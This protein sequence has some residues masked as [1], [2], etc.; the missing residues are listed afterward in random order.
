MRTAGAR[1]PSIRNGALRMQPDAQHRLELAHLGVESRG[2]LTAPFREEMAVR[3]DQV[4]TAPFARADHLLRVSPRNPESRHLGD[5]VEHR[6]QIREFVHDTAADETCGD[7]PRSFEQ[8]FVR[9]VRHRTCRR[10]DSLRRGPKHP[11]LSDERTDRAA[12]E[13]AVEQMWRACGRKS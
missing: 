11:S 6:E 1:L 12:S 4:A 5:A 9:V 3:R 13:Q 2:G 7:V 8:V 10:R